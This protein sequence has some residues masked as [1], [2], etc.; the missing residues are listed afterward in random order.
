[1]KRHYNSWHKEALKV[2]ILDEDA[3]DVSVP[4]PWCQNWKEILIDENIKPR[5]AKFGR[6]KKKC[7][8]FDCLNKREQKSQFKEVAEINAEIQQKESEQTI[9]D[10]ESNKPIGA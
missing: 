9:V 1:M 7:I 4:D 2:E 10:D 6:G 8:D 5:E 3:E